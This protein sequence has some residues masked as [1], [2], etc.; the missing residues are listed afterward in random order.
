M[1]KLFLHYHCENNV[2]THKN[3]RQPL[4]KILIL[5]F[6]PDISSLCIVVVSAVDRKWAWAKVAL[7]KQAA[8]CFD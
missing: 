6:I 7:M 3:I 4:M 2:K 1:L 5:Y 8:Q